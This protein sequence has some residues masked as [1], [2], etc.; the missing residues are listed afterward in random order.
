M[1]FL[2]EKVTYLKIT[3]LIITMINMYICSK[4]FIT[5]YSD[6]F[7]YWANWWFHTFMSFLTLSSLMITSNGRITTFKRVP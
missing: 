7:Y 3:C 6:P 2:R 1:Y 5:A 4:Y